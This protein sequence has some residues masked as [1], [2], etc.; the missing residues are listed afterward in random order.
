MS[1]TN[2]DGWDNH[3]WVNQEEFLERATKE[4]HTINDRYYGGKLDINKTMSA[5]ALKDFMWKAYT[6]CMETYYDHGRDC[7]HPLRHDGDLTVTKYKTSY[8]G[9]CRRWGMGEG[10]THF[11]IIS[12]RY[13]Q[14]WGSAHILETLYHEI[15][16][17]TYFDHDAGFWAEGERIGY[18]LAP[19]G[20]KPRPAKFR[21]YCGQPG[22]DWEKFYVS[23]PNKWV[24]CPYCFPYGDDKPEPNFDTWL[25]LPSE[26]KV[27]TIIERYKGPEI[28]LY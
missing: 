24:I 22:C 20:V 14:D 1:K 15:G 3:V 23:R 18:G 10:A 6:Y 25:A 27:W 19:K 8:A 9:L 12:Y 17:L 21:Q 7:K 26:K 28:L 13:Y 5:E 16:H 4:W 2:D 11:I